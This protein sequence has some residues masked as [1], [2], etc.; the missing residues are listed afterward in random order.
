MRIINALATL[1]LL[2]QQSSTA[3]AQGCHG[4][5]KGVTYLSDEDKCNCYSTS[6]TQD[7][8]EGDMG[9]TW[10]TECPA[11]DPAECDPLK[12]ETEGAD[13]NPSCTGPPEA[14]DRFGKKMFR[15]K[16]ISREIP[17]IPDEAGVFCHVIFE[18]CPGESQLTHGM[19]SG[20]GDYYRLGATAEWQ[21]YKGTA[22]KAYAGMNK[23]TG[24]RSY[25][26]VTPLSENT[27][28]LTI[29]EVVGDE[30]D[31]GCTA[32]LDCLYGMSELVCMA[33][34]GAY[35]L[36]SKRPDHM[37]YE[38]THQAYV[39][40]FSREPGSGPYTINVIGQGVALT[41][42]NLVAL[43][44]MLKPYSVDGSFSQIHTVNYLWAN[45]YWESAEWMWA[46]TNSSDL[47]REMIRLSGTY[48]IRFN[49]MHSISRQSR[50]EAEWPRTDVNVIGQAFKL[51]KTT[52][53]DPNIKW[54]VVGSGNYKRSLYPQILEWGFDM[55]PCNPSAVNKGYPYC[56]PN[57][58]YDQL[59]PGL[60]P[61]ERERS[62]LFKYYEAQPTEPGMATVDVTI[63]FDAYP[64][65]ISWTL[66]NTCNGKEE[67]DSGGNYGRSDYQK[68]ITNSY[69]TPAGSWVLEVSDS[70][71]DG[72]CCDYG[73]G[74]VFIDVN[75]DEVIRNNMEN[76]SSALSAEFHS[77]GGCDGP[78]VPGK[79]KIGINIRF[80][81][82]P[83][84]IS[85]EFFNTCGGP[86]GV[87]VAEGRGYGQDL[88]NQVYGA[89]GGS[90]ED[91]KF[92]FVIKDSFG[93]GLCCNYGNGGYEIFY[94]SD[95]PFSSSFKMSAEET[96]EFGSLD[97]CESTPDDRATSPLDSDLDA[98][99]CKTVS[100][101]GT[102]TTVGT[103]LLVGKTVFGE[104]NGP[105]TLDEC[106]DGRD[107]T[108]K[109]D[110]SNEAITVMSI[111]SDMK[112]PNG[113]LTGGEKAMIHAHV[114][115]FTNPAVEDVVDF[116]HA[117]DAYNPSWEYIGTTQPLVGGLGDVKSPSFT[118]SNGEMQAVRV[119][120]RW[121]GAGAYTEVGPC[122][123]GEYND[124][125]DLAFAV[126]DG[127]EEEV[128]ITVASPE[129][130]P[131]GPLSMI[132]EQVVECVGY[133]SGR[134]A[135]ADGCEWKNDRCQ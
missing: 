96:H 81:G 9:G 58:L 41:E 107:G 94:E 45:S 74:N 61:N 8:C 12:E 92:L 43:S 131:Q 46:D 113:P 79:V 51:T 62:D 2:E 110:E 130:L 133:D 117:S 28:Q 35:F 65:D 48:G 16:L 126:N 98:P 3:S 25:S 5:V 24:A 78:P 21:D 47:S 123:E 1:F 75:G 23:P 73:F 14:I 84:D 115:A 20:F 86:A 44:E 60:D 90:I 53:Q 80:D 13:S 114:F 67:L 129:A 55:Y 95:S 87:K 101:S 38:G 122:P 27:V 82:F 22:G 120:V 103:G 34:I 119:I 132:T 33:P 88:A 127:E 4:G 97:S 30:V 85:W 106:L 134:C 63:K 59:A 118:L 108:Y 42:L 100:A 124:I 64:M 18:L 10:T 111:G 66:Y 68:A 104:P 54:F 15:R 29:K 31:Y 91:G 32:D 36:L 76:P 7:T 102:C 11:C 26:P 57:A 69:S 99:S 70:F 77:P 128:G 72:L 109:Q 56:G 17:D 6:C 19:D 83:E 125:D 71:G 52:D 37:G 39:P 135:A 40:N 93:D 112:M 105:N 89:F 116:Y 50:P 121:V 49:L